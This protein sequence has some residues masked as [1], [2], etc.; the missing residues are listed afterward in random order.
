MAGWQEMRVVELLALVLL[1][2][3]D[4]R[5]WLSRLKI[6]PCSRAHS[7]TASCSTIQRNWEARLLLSQPT[8]HILLNWIIRWTEAQ[9]PTSWARCQPM[10]D[11]WW[12]QTNQVHWRHRFAWSGT[13]PK[14]VKVTGVGP[15][16][17]APPDDFRLSCPDSRP[18]FLLPSDSTKPDPL[19]GQSPSHFHVWLLHNLALAGMISILPAWPQDNQQY[20]GLAD[21]P[22]VAPLRTDINLAAKGS[23]I[24]PNHP[25]AR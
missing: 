25:V 16:S 12:G 14:R 18:K 6:L 17:N 20:L 24:C 7:T 8:F 15:C 22:A 4:Y 21:N 9:V 11:L 2:P 10:R 1:R 23:L 13:A 3:I 5:P 19:S